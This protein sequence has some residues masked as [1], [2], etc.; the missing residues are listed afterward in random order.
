MLKLHVVQAEF[1]DCLF[2]EY[3]SGGNSKFI[4]IDGGP[5][6]IY[7]LHLKQ[8]LE[9]IRQQSSP[10]EAAVLSHSDADH[11]TGLLD[12]FSD[13]QTSGGA[14]SL[15]RPAVLWHNSF[16]KTIDVNNA[17]AP[18]MQTLQAQSP[19]AF[20]ADSGIAIHGVGEGNALRLK[21]LQLNIPLNDGFPNSLV[22]A[23]TAPNPISFD[24]LELHVV[25]PTQEDL[26]EL[27]QE[28]DDWLNEHEDAIN[29]GNPFVMANSDRSV[30]NLSS[31]MLYAKADGKTILLTGDGRSDHLLNGLETAGLLQNGKLHV[32]VLKLMHH[33]SDRNVTKT[34]FKKVTADTYVASANGRDDNPD[35][36]TLIWIAEAAQEQQREITIFVTND[37]PSVASFKE[38]YPP[39]E[40]GYKLKIMPKTKHSLALDL[41]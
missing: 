36:A 14:G 22:L 25:G 34:F 29:S 32:D 19:Q 40:Y 1:G 38:Q 13:L 9:S 21:A 23:D 24:N 16:S 5:A 18:R 33:G 26:D 7:P 12:Y 17:L 2:L 10:L 31:I 41:A 28:W 20:S 15:P 6:D 4:L 35:L 37:T 11:I 30:P 3:G 8:F 39:A 27:R